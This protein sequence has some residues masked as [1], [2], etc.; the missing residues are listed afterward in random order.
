MAAAAA[1]AL[2]CAPA[3]VLVASTGVIGVRLPMD[4][5]RAGIADAGRPALARRRAP[6]PRAPS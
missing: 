5:V 4:K 3:E 1:A 2:G 6:T